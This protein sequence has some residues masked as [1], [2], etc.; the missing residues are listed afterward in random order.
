VV[1]P[2]AADR[3]RVR[4][5]PAVG[6]IVTNLPMPDAI[7]SRVGPNQGTVGKL[8]SRRVRFACNTVRM[9]EFCKA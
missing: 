2:G 8:S 4:V 3:R 6:A 5:S 7:V 9:M 1:E